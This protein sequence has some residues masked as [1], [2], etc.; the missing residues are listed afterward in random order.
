MRGA[1]RWFGRNHSTRRT[2]RSYW[3]SRTTL[4]NW[5]RDLYWTGRVET[6]NPN[7]SHSS[8]LVVDDHEVVRTGLI[9][10]LQSSGASRLTQSSSFAE[11]SARLTSESF[12]VAIIDHHLG[13]GIGLDLALLA[14]ASNPECKLALLTLE[15]EWQLIE[16]SQSMG[17]QAFIS[18]RCE[19]RE[20]IETVKLVLAGGD[21]F[22]LRVPQISRNR[23]PSENKSF[24]LTRTELS[25]LSDLADGSSTREIAVKRCNSEATIKTHL[26]SIYRKLGARNRIEALIIARDFNVK[27]F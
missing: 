21:F 23:E 5:G 22:Y 13:D 24:K 10:A 26:T 11:A 2:L 3:N 1:R 17:F 7:I 8:I 19:L 14:T 15:E 9:A 4:K 25:I 18:K 12:D 27:N 20:I 16:Q 6:I